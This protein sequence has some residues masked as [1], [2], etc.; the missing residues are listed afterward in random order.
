MIKAVLFDIDGVMLDSFD[1][2]LQFYRN[3][4][5]EAGYRPPTAEEYRQ[6]FHL[7]MIGAIQALTGIDS[8]DELDSIWLKGLD[9]TRLYPFSLVK[10]ASD[11]PSAIKSLAEKYPLGLVTSRIRMSVYAV[12][13]LA[14]L[15]KFFTVT[16][17]YED[18]IE[19][20]PQP[21]PLLL[22]ASKLGVAP[23]NCVYIG[24][25]ET[26]FKAAK[27]AGMKIIMYH[28]PVLAKADGYISA[29]S[30]LPEMIARL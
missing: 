10:M 8:K 27:A 18:V 11:V 14:E 23:E 13:Q 26:D 22:A 2:N 4:L 15:E 17:T 7:T 21:E 24:D 1:A 16:I 28:N 29:F 9:R 5:T 6:V 3:L 12:P 19:H 30:E 20:K 25:A